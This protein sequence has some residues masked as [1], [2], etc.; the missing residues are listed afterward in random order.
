MGCRMPI[1]SENKLE[2]PWD[3]HRQLTLLEPIQ[4]APFMTVIAARMNS[5]SIV[6]V[7][8]LAPTLIT[9]R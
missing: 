9:S 7:E 6:L 5:S 3:I 2:Q 8:N 1:S 4:S